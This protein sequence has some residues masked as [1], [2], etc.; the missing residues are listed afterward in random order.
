VISSPL[1]S[2]KS[3]YV[4]KDCL[5]LI[6]GLKRKDELQKATLEFIHL[7]ARKSGID[8][9]DFGVHGSVALGMHTSKSDMD[10]VVY[11]SGNFRRLEST[12]GKLVKDKALSYVCSNRLDAARRFKGRYRGR[13]FMYN[14]IRKPEE[15]TS[16]YG[17]HKYRPLAHVRFQCEVNDDSE[18]MFRPAVY[19]IG[20]YR[21]A[22]ADSVL[23]KDR[24]PKLVVSMIG[25]YRNVARQG[26]QMRVAGMLER[27]ENLET[28]EVTH[29]V[30]VGTGVSEEEYIWPL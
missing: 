26:D 20:D 23:P 11:G 12:V 28:G 22:D 29:Q 8:M 15:I 18:A 27:V 14:A 7:L 13:I 30:V 10:A 17:T 4:P 24:I 19:E 25:C 9:G 2:V 1:A 16:K 5:H 21:P 3:V 6:A